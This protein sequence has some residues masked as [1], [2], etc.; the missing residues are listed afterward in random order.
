MADN[1]KISVIIPVYNAQQYIEECIASVIRQSLKDLEILCVDDGSTDD[2][3]FIL[4]KIQQNDARIRIIEQPNQGSGKARNQG[5]LQARGEF[6]LFLDADDYLLDVSA[7]EQMYQACKAHQASI[8]GAFRNIDREGTVAPMSLHRRECEGYPDGR[9]MSYREYQYAF[10]FSTYLFERRLLM[11]HQILFPDYRRFQDPP[12]FVKAMIAAEEFY[13]M[14][15]ELYCFRSGHQNYTFSHRQVND[16]VRGLTDIL[17]MSGE[18]GLTKLHLLAVSRLNEG[19]FWNI[20][21][22]LTVENAELLSLIL[23][24]DRTV[25][26]DWVQPACDGEA[27]LLKPL[28]FLLQAGA[29][30]CESYRLEL[31]QRGYENVQLGCVFPFHRV[32]MGSRVILYAAGVMGW[33]YYEQI[34]DSTDYVLAAWVDRQYQKYADVSPKIQSVETIHTLDYDYI[35]IAIEEEWTALQI[36]SSLK[37]AGVPEEKIIWCLSI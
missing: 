20:V 10:H 1:I 13:I 16:I 8:C 34:K 4:H 28:Q 15:V 27:L 35:V 36:I 22:H 3:Q 33:T 11:D 31:G 21:Q 6:L 2:S 25:R 24:A 23:K 26:R 19:F 14:P 9:K 29:Q 18:A 37:E 7:L 5:I 12:F 17:A 32:P 30:R